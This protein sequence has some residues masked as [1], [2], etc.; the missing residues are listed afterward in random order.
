[1]VL[2]GI[3]MKDKKISEKS[4]EIKTF[5]VENPASYLPDSILSSFLSTEGLFCSHVTGCAQ[6][7]DMLFLG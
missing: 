4:S 5:P 1:M 2:D 6:K 3:V 7:Y